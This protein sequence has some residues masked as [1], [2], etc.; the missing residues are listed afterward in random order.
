MSGLGCH[1]DAQILKTPDWH[2]TKSIRVRL[3]TC[4]VAENGFGVMA[5][6]PWHDT[7]GCDFK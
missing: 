4:A 6:G 2:E 3:S 5:M 7:D 1:T